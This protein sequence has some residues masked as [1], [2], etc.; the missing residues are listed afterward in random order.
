[1]DRTQFASLIEQIYEIMRRDGLTLIDYVEQLSWILFLKLLDDEEKK[2]ELLHYESESSYTPLIEKKYRF[3]NWP[4]AVG[5]KNFEMAD[6]E[7]LKKFVEEEV[8]PYLR[9]LS[10]SPERE[11]I[12]EIFRNITLKIRDPHNFKEILLKIKDIDFNNPEDTHIMSQLYEETLMMM[13][14]EG[15][16]AGEYY[17]PRPVVRFMVKV[18]DPKPNETIFDPFCGSGGFLVESYRYIVEKYGDKLSLEEYKSLSKNFYGQ[19]LKPLAFLIA[20]MNTMLHGLQANIV[21]KDTFSENIISGPKERYKVIL[22][23]PPFGGKLS[24]NQKEN[25]PI[26]VTA[27]ELAALQYVMRK[28]EPGGRVGI[29]LPDGVLSNITKSYVKVRKELVEKN[30]VFAIVSLP[31]GVFANISPKGGSGPKASLLFFERGKPTKEIWYYEL[32]PPNGKN[33]TRANPIKY[34]DLKDALEKFEAWRK[35]LETG[36]KKWRKKA[37][38][39]NSWVVSIEEIKENDYDLSARNPNKKLTVEYPAP[40]EIIAS[41]EEK[42]RKIVE[43]LGEIKSILGEKP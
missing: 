28:V 30:N 9:N 40:E 22:T 10:G 15:G 35:Y 34:E 41:L 13:G 32:V 42:E 39:E 26:P 5:A 2:K 19:E 38:S 27:S 23:N 31:Q 16:A 6:A 3:S 12:A 11:K 25:L 21:L 43:L 18:I 36:D 8:L 7:K 24:K 17:T 1:M 37:I 33:Y 20:T 14:R 29:V 4:S